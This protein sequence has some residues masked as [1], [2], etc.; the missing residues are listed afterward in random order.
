MQVKVD[1]KIN[2]DAAFEAT[3]QQLDDIGDDWVDWSVLDKLEK[4][5][6]SKKQAESIDEPKSKRRKQSDSKTDLRK[7]SLSKNI[8]KDVSD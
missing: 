2:N 6:E 1:S 4:K 7:T 8:K 3:L 5:N